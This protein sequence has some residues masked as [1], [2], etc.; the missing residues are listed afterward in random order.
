MKSQTKT[1]VKIFTALRDPSS[2][3][4]Y[5]GWIR[6]S[7]I[8]AIILLF[9]ALSLSWKLDGLSPLLAI[10]ALPLAAHGY[11][12]FANLFRVKND[13]A[14]HRVGPVLI[15]ASYFAGIMVCVL[16]IRPDEAVY[17]PF[18]GIF[19]AILTMGLFFTGLAPLLAFW[20]TKYVLDRGVSKQ[21]VIWCFVILT[22]AWT[23]S[24]VTGSALGNA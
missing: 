20:I 11:G 1:Q 3:D 14:P 17:M 5:W 12:F 21:R 24:G 8:A 15:G 23:L 13:P 19:M 10:G 22:V 6:L 4:H 18:V 2:V 16:L 7:W 9:P